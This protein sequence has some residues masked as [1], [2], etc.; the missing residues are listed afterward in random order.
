MAVSFLT[1]LSLTL[2]SFPYTLGPPRTGFLFLLYGS[3]QRLEDS[4]Y[5]LCPNRSFLTPAKY[6]IFFPS[7]SPQVMRSPQESLPCLVP[8]LRDFI[9]LWTSPILS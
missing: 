3:P 9:A 1:D 6:P 2:C 7:T 8:L 5:T 4:S